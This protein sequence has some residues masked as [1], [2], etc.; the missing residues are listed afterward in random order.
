MTLYKMGYNRFIEKNQQGSHLEN[1]LYNR[2]YRNSRWIKNR[3]LYHTMDHFTACSC[4]H[5]R[6]IGLFTISPL[7]R[8]W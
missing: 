5:S 6:E 7:D 8:E 4:A 3:H 2:Y 1:I